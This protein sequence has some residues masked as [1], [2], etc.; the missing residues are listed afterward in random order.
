MQDEEFFPSLFTSIPRSAWQRRAVSS[1]EEGYW[2]DGVWLC[3]WRRPVSTVRR[4]IDLE[5]SWINKEGFLLS[6]EGEEG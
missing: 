4:S 6:L 3:S 1:K 5:Y 2:V